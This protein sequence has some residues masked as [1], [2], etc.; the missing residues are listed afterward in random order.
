MTPEEYKMH[1]GLVSTRNHYLNLTFEQAEKVYKFEQ[2]KGI[3]SESQIFS[4]WEFLDYEKTVFGEILNAEQFEKYLEHISE[5]IKHIEQGLIEQDRERINYIAYYKEIISF[6]ET[7]ILPDLFNSAFIHVNWFL[8]DK[9]K[10]VYLRSAYQQFL[11]ERKKEILIN[12]FR[13]NRTFKPN[14]LKVSLLRHKFAYIFPDYGAF[15]FKMD[16]PTK[17]IARYLT[18]KYQQ[19][20]KQLEELFES[21]FAELKDFNQK[22]NKKYF[23]ERN[24]AIIIETQLTE[25]ERKEHLS[26]SFLLLDKEGYGHADA[27]LQPVL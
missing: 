2:D 21:K 5:N 14:E 13:Y 7:H 24:S 15:K 16:E 27:F 25:E 17:A 9:P 1:V 19:L 18:T 22:K 3:Y 12:H 10:V 23:G 6:Y 11:N 8:N 20:P 26:M 4:A